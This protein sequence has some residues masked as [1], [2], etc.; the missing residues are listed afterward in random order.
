MPLLVTLCLS[1]ASRRTRGAGAGAAAPRG[2]LASGPLREAGSGGGGGAEWAPLRQAATVPARAL[3]GGFGGGGRAEYDGGGDGGGGGAGL[4]RS[5][6]VGAVRRSLSG[7][8]SGGLGAGKGSGG[9]GGGEGAASRDGRWDGEDVSHGASDQAR[10]GP[11]SGLRLSESVGP[12]A[13]LNPVAE[14]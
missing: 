13:G 3:S 12:R 14:L 5:A 11:G 2:A 8:G 4:R 10:R 7:K 9:F 6:T 1:R